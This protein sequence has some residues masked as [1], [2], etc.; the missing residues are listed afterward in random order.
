MYATGAA[1]SS[2]Q[3]VASTSTWANRVGTPDIAH[4]MPAI[5]SESTVKGTAK[6]SAVFTTAGRDSCAEATSS[7]MRWYCESA[8][9]WVARMV[10]A[11][12]P[13][14]APDITRAPANT[15]RGTGSPLILLR[16][17]VAVPDSS[18]PSTGTVSPGSTMSTSPSC[19]CSTGTVSKRCAAAAADAKPTRRKPSDESPLSVA[20]PHPTPG[21]LTTCAVC[22]AASISAVRLRSALAWAYSSMASP[23][24]IISV[25]A[26]LAQYSATATVER[27]ATTASTSTPTCP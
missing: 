5:I 20:N 13:F 1:M 17:S 22:G 14:T 16:S 12:E 19:T 2:G 9:T 3:G 7:R 11:V 24:V 26:Q 18:S 8:A 25:T 27:I 4:A 23:D 10:N 6:R 21:R 15:S